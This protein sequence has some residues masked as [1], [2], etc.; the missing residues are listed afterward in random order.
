VEEG[1]TLSLLGG[2]QLGAQGKRRMKAEYRAEAHRGITRLV[3]TQEGGRVLA[4]VRL[5]QNGGEDA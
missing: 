3:L 5:Q 2:A 4:D 1:P